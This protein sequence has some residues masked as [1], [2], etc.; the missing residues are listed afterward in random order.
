DG[1]DRGAVVKLDADIDTDV[2]KLPFDCL[3]DVLA[4]REACLCHQGENQPLAVALPH[5]V[6]ASLP[7]G[8]VEQRTRAHRVEAIPA[9]GVRICP[10]NWLNR[11]V[12]NRRKA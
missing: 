9:D 8:L 2:A 5:T 6:S 1:A 11:A 12:G 7:A 3:C 10:G 4:N